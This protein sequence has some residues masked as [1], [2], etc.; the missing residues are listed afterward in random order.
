VLTETDIDNLPDDPELALAVIADMLLDRIKQAG[1]DFGMNEAQAW[2]SD[3]LA[4]LTVHEMADAY[5]ALMDDYPLDPGRFWEWWNTYLAAL[6]HH[7][8]YIYMEKKRTLTTV[9]IAPPHRAK[10]HQLLNEIRELV[11]R[12]NITEEKRNLIYKLIAKLASEVD[13]TRT[14]VQTMLNTVLQISRVARQ[15]GED[16]KPIVDRVRELFG[17]FTKAE[18]APQ[19]GHKKPPQIGRKMPRPQARPKAELDDD[20]PF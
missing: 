12:L 6:R 3:I 11:E 20:I 18:D 5:K 17:I 7:R 14:G 8:T 15:I 16:A 19:L 4:H 9:V 2:H 13:Q 10:I 1:E